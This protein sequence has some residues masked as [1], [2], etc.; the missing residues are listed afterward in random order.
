ML[1][2]LASVVQACRVWSEFTD[3]FQ[4]SGSVLRD[5]GVSDVGA[6]GAM[7]DGRIGSATPL[8][9]FTVVNIQAI[10]YQSSLCS[11]AKGRDG[12]VFSLTSGASLQRMGGKGSVAPFKAIC[13]CKY[14]YIYIYIHIY[15]YDYI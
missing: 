8:Q 1:S 3:S 10:Q 2:V 5:H 11:R 14:I 6:T 7:A 13:W 4:S 15:I 9:S 12:F